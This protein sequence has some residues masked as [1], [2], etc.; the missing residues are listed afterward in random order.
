V[1]YE[2]AL[3]PVNFTHD[4]EVGPLS[5]LWAL[6]EG[7]LA[8]REV[9]DEARKGG[10]IAC[11]PDCRH[12][13]LD[14]IVVGGESG[15][16]ARPFDLAWARS[17]IAQCRAAGVPVFVKQLGARP[18]ESEVTRHAVDCSCSLHHGFIDRKGGEMAEWPEDL[19][20]REFPR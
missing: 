4:T 17:T 13:G 5:Y 16:G 8:R 2:P 9:C 20:V 14:W 18:I 10:A 1:S 19:Q 15:P 6:C 11:C 12:V 7:C 3:G